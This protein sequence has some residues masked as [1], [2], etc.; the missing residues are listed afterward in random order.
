MIGFVHLGLASVSKCPELKLEESESQA[1]A[2]ATT[3][4]MREFDMAPDPKVV[5]VVGLITT[6]STIYG[7][8]VYMISRRKTEDKEKKEDILDVSGTFGNVSPI[9]SGGSLSG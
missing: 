3:N 9:S 1:L 2:Q 6:A 8:R 7:P 4:V 5:A